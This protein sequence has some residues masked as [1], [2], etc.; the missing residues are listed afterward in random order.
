M[1]M[2]IKLL[3]AGIIFLIAGLIMRSLKMKKP[4][5]AQSRVFKTI[6]EW[7]ETIW[8]AV[9]LAAFIMYFFIQAFKIPSGSM[10]N[11]LLIGDHLFVNKFAY[12][13]QVPF[14]GGKRALP[15]FSVKRGNI[16]IFKCPPE[17]LSP[18]EKQAGVKKDFIKRAIGIPGDTIEIIDKKVFVN[19]QE[20][21][22]P[23][24]NFE[25][26]YIQ[27]RKAMFIRA[28]NYQASWEQGRFTQQPVR[29]N[30]GPVVVPQG[31]YFV[32]GDNRD[33][34]FDSRFWGPLNDKYLKG[35]ALFIYW[36]LTRIRL[37]K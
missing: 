29:D 34:S 35:K 10:I 12:G 3:I 14:S 18:E 32:M 20:Q 24:T 26:D 4:E 11:T 21:I 6:Y 5:L 37:I 1:D 8:S 16:V 13:F 23:Y 19:G 22:E 25:I 15:I 36:P 30:F 7:V 27:P 17:A 33:K 28:E 31:C 2:E 9:L